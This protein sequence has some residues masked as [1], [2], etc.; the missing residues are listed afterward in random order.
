[1]NMEKREYFAREEEHLKPRSEICNDVFQ[2]FITVSAWLS[3]KLFHRICLHS[4]TYCYASPFQNQ[5]A[6][7]RV[8]VPSFHWDQCESERLWR[9][10][11]IAVRNNELRFLSVLIVKQRNKCAEWKIENWKNPRHM[12]M[13][14]LFRIEIVLELKPWYKNVWV[15]IRP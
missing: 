14:E 4:D 3:L 15:R 6:K 1:M 13:N 2:L 8:V 10:K 9:D 7:Y 12:R 11:K 5:I